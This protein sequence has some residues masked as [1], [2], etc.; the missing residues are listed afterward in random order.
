MSQ[1]NVILK[2]DP[3]PL[4][5]FEDVKEIIVSGSLEKLGRSEEQQK[6]YDSFYDNV[7]VKE[8][9]SG[10]DYILANKFGAQTEICDA[11]R[12]VIRPLQGVKS[13]VLLLPNDFPYHFEPN[14]SHFILWKLNGAINIEEI[15]AAIEDLKTNLPVLEST[16]YTN[17]SHLKSIPEIDHAHIVLKIRQE[18]NFSYCM[19]NKALIG[20]SCVGVCYIAY[21]ALRA[22]SIYDDLRAMR[23]FVAR[24]KV[25]TLRAALQAWVNLFIPSIGKFSVFRWRR[26]NILPAVK[27][28]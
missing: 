17:P 3:I 7:I 26:Q 12:S 1:E 24:P 20:F 5:S 4:L 28:P 11:R 2:R 23:E 19:I 10:G 18:K 25:S 9:K 21:V 16:Y 27:D 22:K 8:W 13:T 15:N 14:I 6:V